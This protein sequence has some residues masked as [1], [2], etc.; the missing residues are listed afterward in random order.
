MVSLI[1]MPPVVMNIILEYSNYRQILT[2]RKVCRDFRNYIDDVKPDIKLHTISVKNAD[3]SHNWFRVD[4][5]RLEDSKSL[6]CV[7]ISGGGCRLMVQ[8]VKEFT[9]EESDPFNILKEDLRFLLEFQKSVLIALNVETSNQEVLNFMKDILKSRNHF[10]KVKKITFHT[11]NQ[12]R[13]LSILPYIDPE[14]IEEILISEWNADPSHIN[15]IVKLDQWKRLK[16]I[17]LCTFLKTI[18]MRNFSHFDVGSINVQ[19]IIW[20]DL[21]LLKEA[22]RRSSFQKFSISYRYLDNE[23]KL[24]ETLGPSIVH[25]GLFFDREWY[26]HIPNCDQILNVEHST[27]QQMIKFKKIEK[28]EVIPNGFIQN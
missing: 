1:E 13:I 20:Q 14:N 7:K 19:S 28:S 2:L 24:H 12:S 9:L 5:S 17:S 23:K 6:L 11:S 8:G 16:S 15:K 21:I 22:F 25:L 4:F 26:Y 10:L 3:N 27:L 18:S